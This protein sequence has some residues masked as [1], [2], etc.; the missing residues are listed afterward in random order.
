MLEPEYSNLTCVEEPLCE[1]IPDMY[2]C[3]QDIH[4]ND[5]WYACRGYRLP[6]TAE[7]EY[8]ARAG[9]TTDTYNGDLLANPKNECQEQANLNDIA[10]YC[11]NSDDSLHP[12]AKKQPNS[13]GLYDILGNALEWV[14][15]FNDGG[16]LDYMD[17]HPG[18]DLVDPIGRITGHSKDLRGGRFNGIG[19]LARSAR[20]FAWDETGRLE[21]AGFRPV[22]TLSE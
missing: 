20:Q 22:R 16:S 11:F 14:D 18:E 6:T 21:T 4:K 12:V 9:T 19:C 15:Y 5:D 3:T 1:N 17:N 7:W 10:W 8:V 2:R 13:W